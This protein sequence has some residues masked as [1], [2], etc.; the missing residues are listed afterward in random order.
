MLPK[1]IEV[2][3]NY[4][5]HKLFNFLPANMG[6]SEKRKALLKSFPNVSHTSIYDWTRKWQSELT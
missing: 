2:H 3:F 1:Q 5:A 6:L 4:P